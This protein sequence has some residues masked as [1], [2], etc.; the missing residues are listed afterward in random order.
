MKASGYVLV[1]STDLGR[2]SV[3]N[4]LE[5]SCSEEGEHVL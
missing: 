5:G 4:D 1:N 2:V 3:D